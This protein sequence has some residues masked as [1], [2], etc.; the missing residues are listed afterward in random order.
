M[1]NLIFYF[2]SFYF[3]NFI[4]SIAVKKIPKAKSSPAV[5]TQKKKPADVD[6]KFK[7]F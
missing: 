1:L 7:K 3:L 4:F 5:T 2:I 6:L